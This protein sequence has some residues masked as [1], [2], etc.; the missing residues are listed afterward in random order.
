MLPC[1][2]RVKDQDILSIALPNLV[3]LL[4]LRVVN[5]SYPHRSRPGIIVSP[6]PSIRVVICTR[7]CRV[8]RVYLVK[9][10]DLVIGRRLGSLHTQ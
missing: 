8:Q 2:G 1:T 9:E 3:Y 10:S 4:N 6:E 5:L 7:S